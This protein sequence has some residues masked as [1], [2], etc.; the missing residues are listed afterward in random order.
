[1]NGKNYELNSWKEKHHALSEEIDRLNQVINEKNALIEEMTLKFKELV[2]KVRN[3]EMRKSQF[4]E[5][6]KKTMAN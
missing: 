6:M 5:E 4:L 2:G 1:M 3:D